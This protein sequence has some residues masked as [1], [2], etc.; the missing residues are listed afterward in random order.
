MIQLNDTLFLMPS[1]INSQ[2]AWITMA[3]GLGRLSN[4]ML[5][6]GRRIAVARGYIY[7]MRHEAAVLTPLGQALLNLTQ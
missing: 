6:T 3:D 7:K 1:S 5:V 2:Y 4:E